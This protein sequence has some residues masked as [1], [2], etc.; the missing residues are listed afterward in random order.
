MNA[1][2][3]MLRTMH[4]R[5]QSLHT[6]LRRD[7]EFII[8]NANDTSQLIDDGKIN[9]ETT[10]ISFTFVN[11]L[12]FVWNSNKWSWA[13]SSKTLRICLCHNSITRFNWPHFNDNLTTIL[14]KCNWQ[15]D[16]KYKLHFSPWATFRIVSN[17]RGYDLHE[18]KKCN[19]LGCAE[20]WISSVETNVGQCK[21]SWE[22]LH[23]LNRLRLD[24]GWKYNTEI[25]FL[26]MT[27]AMLFDYQNVRYFSRNYLLNLLIYSS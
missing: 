17:E 23:L 27:F 10:T 6:T 21:V 16:R 19:S 12:T 22:C 1:Q 7:N 9:M 3:L 15:H 24:S 11:W 14:M 26:E 25:M 13:V 20:K 2:L 4:H 18:K 5:S 8:R